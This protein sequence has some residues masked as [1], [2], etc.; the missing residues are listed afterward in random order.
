MSPKSHPKLPFSRLLAGL[1]AVLLTTCLLP[2]D[3]G[4]QKKNKKKKASAKAVASTLEAIDGHLDAYATE[5][6]RD[7]LGDLAKEQR[8]AEVFT[9]LGRILEQEKEYGVAEKRLKK[10][11]DFS[12]KDPAPWV[13]LGWTYQHQKKDGKAKEA[14]GKAEQLAAA[15]AEA[16]PEDAG[17]HLHL[18][19]ARAHLGQHAAAVASLKQARKLAPKSAD[20]AY[21]LGF[22]L[23][24]QEKW[25]PAVDELSVAIDLDPDM[26]YAYF[27]RGQ[28]ASK[29]KRKDMLIADLEKFLKLAPDAP[30]APIAKRA[31][32][33]VRR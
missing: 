26:A 4:A 12:P 19:T 31:L 2:A 32:A 14:Y 7:A 3:A 16:A 20:A 17:A 18:G 5:A 13:W 10:A 30:E 21:Q 11:A 8:T 23:A 22:A 1:L 25:K 27:Y 9:T 29:V 15:A 24:L 33:A 28:A 6:A